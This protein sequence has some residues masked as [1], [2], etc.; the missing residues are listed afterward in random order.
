M[1]IVQ[2]EQ[3]TESQ[4]TTWNDF[5]TI[6]WSILL[7]QKVLHFIQTFFMQLQR[8]IP[9]KTFQISVYKWSKK[10]PQEVVQAWVWIPVSLLITVWLIKASLSSYL[11][12]PFIQPYYPG[13]HSDLSLWMPKLIHRK[14]HPENF[15]PENN[16]CQ[17]F[18]RITSA[19]FSVHSN[20]P[21]SH[22]QR[23]S[24]ACAKGP[25][26]WCWL[27]MWYRR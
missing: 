27:S 9:R 15:S 20:N 12:N 13:V 4:S 22:C 6:D 14:S 21:I 25:L 16:C 19:A 23:I 11:H 1:W 24:S 8:Q 17:V 2:Y 10:L 3:R 26:P 18:P 5:L 7:L